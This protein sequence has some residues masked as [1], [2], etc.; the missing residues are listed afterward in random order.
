MK[1]YVLHLLVELTSSKEEA[2]LKLVVLVV[3]CPDVFTEIIEVVVK[4]FGTVTFNVVV[5]AEIIVAVVILNLTSLSEIVELKFVP[6]IVTVPPIESLI[7]EKLLIVGASI[8]VV[9]SGLLQEKIIVIIKV[10]VKQG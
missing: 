6:I 7:G 3:V 10:I 9:G 2:S 8:W 5:V 4:S 1:T